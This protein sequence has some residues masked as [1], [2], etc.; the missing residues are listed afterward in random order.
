M[1]GGLGLGFAIICA[2]VVLTTG[3]FTI[4]A[5]AGFAGFAVLAIVFTVNVVVGVSP[6]AETLFTDDTTVLNMD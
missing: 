3:L 5:C 6:V 4:V 2:A 1:V